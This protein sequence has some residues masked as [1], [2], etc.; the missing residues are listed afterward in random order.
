MKA[1]IIVD[2]LNDFVNGILANEKNANQIIPSIQKLIEHARKNPTEWLIVYSN[3]SHK[4]DDEEI[5]V[6]GKH[7]MEGTEGAQVIEPLKP[8]GI[9]NEIISPKRFY[10]AFDL[11]G[12]GEIFEKKGGVTEV[13]IVGQHTNCC[14]RHTAYGAFIRG[15][16]IKV[17]SDCVCVFK[18]ADN[19]DA[20]DYLKN[21]YGSII[22]TSND[23]LNN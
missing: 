5:K 2:M 4:E 8:I 13:V 14:V 9:D 21:I 1:L 18:D 15:Y 11:T 22:T 12:L 7:A 10:G 20:L 16:Q 23:I 6:W 3:D 17:P 19:Q